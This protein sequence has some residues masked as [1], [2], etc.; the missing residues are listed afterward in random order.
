MGSGSSD[1]VIGVA[2]VVIVVFGIVKKWT[3]LG[4][5]WEND[6]KFPTSFGLA[7]PRLQKTLFFS[8]IL[9]YIKYQKKRGNS[10]HQIINKIEFCQNKGKWCKMPIVYKPKQS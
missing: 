5:K 9:H 10:F 4:H 3:E 6:N 7:F 2:T 1:G 8:F